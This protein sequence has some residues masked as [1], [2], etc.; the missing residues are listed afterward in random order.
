M[1]SPI[2]RQPERPEL[3]RREAASGKLHSRH[4]S[5]GVARLWAL[6]AP[7]QFER[8]WLFMGRLYPSL[9]RLPTPA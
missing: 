2:P 7:M 8:G 9:P 1:T 3:A 5:S 4:H 6:C